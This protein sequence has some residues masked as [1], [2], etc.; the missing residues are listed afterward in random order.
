[1]KFFMFSQA[2]QARNVMMVGSTNITGYAAHTHW[3]DLFTMNDRPACST[4]YSTI[5]RSSPRTRRCPSRTW[6]SSTGT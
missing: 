6:C 4:A 1:M 5:H 2:G 3:N